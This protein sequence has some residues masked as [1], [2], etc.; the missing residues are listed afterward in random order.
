MNTYHL[1]PWQRQQH[2]YRLKSQY[3]RIINSKVI[4]C[5]ANELF[6]VGVGNAHY[7]KVNSAR[8]VFVGCAVFSFFAVWCQRV[9]T[10]NQQR[11]QCQ[12]RM[13]RTKKAKHTTRPTLLRVIKEDAKILGESKMAF[14]PHEKGVFMA[15]IKTKAP[16]NRVCVFFIANGKT[17]SA[18]KILA[19]RIQSD[20]MEIHGNRCSEARRRVRDCGRECT[21][22][23]RKRWI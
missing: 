6:A 8:S 14:P 11:M 7:Y 12:K 2:A 21:R 17:Y 20:S 13:K 5:L 22:T 19:V 10:L 23:E 1:Q 4:Y 16:R 15:E 18:Y 9:C 3:V